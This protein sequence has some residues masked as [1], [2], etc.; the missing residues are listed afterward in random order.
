LGDEPN[1]DPLQVSQQFS[2]GFVSFAGVEVVFW[3]GHGQ[4]ERR[5]R[6]KKTVIAGKFEQGRDS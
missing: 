4:L 2:R 5:F 6:V 1:A 3:G